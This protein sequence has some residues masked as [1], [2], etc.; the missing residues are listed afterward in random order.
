[1]T[2]LAQ[3]FALDALQVEPLTGT[4]SGPGGREKL[5]PKVMDV[6][7]FMAG[8]AGQV[9]LREDLL[10]RLWPNAVVTDDAITRCF[11]E[12]R[13]CLVRA[14]GNDH[15]RS[16]VETVPKRGYRLNATVQPLEPAAVPPAVPEPEPARVP[17]RRGA[18]IMAAG[19]AA[20]LAMIAA[21][22][23]LWRSPER[24]EAPVGAPEIRAIAVLPFLD[25]SAET[26]QGYF[27][28][29]VTEEILNRLSQAENLRVISRTSSF[30]LRNA[31]LDVPQIADRLGVDY[32]L[33]GSIRKAGGR[34][35]ITAQLIDVGTN[36][37]AWSRTYD[38][39]LDDVFAVQDEIAASVAGAL[40]ATLAGGRLERRGPASVEAYEAYLQGQFFYNRRA[41]GDLE[42]AVSYYETAVERDPGYA[43]AWAALSGA[44]SLL[45]H[46]GKMPRQRGQSLQREA[47]LRAV[48]L[49]P[50]LAVA[51]NRLARYYFETGDR[52]KA[53]EH[54][55]IARALDP[56]DPLVLGGQAGMATRNGDFETAIAIGQRLV[57]SDPLS[58]LQ[59]N[60]LGS[61]L[62]AAGRF[63]EAIAQFRAARELNPESGRDYDYRIAQLHVLLKQPELADAVVHGM[64]PGPYRDQALALLHSLPARRESADAALARIVERSA[65]EP[66]AA[67]AEIY[68]YRGMHE[69]AI[70]ALELAWQA[71]QGNP[72]LV[73]ELSHRFQL[74]LITSPFLEPLRKDP[75]LQ[76]L[77]RKW[78]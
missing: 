9:V 59:R 23:Y 26:D 18:R 65:Q 45:I 41:D 33:E 13:R 8:H 57:A 43:R 42:R 20:V 51:Q 73:P 17:A 50:N 47:A 24:L 38:R 61:D 11:Y 66:S 48:E 74:E 12:L 53:L 6:L 44:Y 27:S 34:V 49:D 25:M 31:N 75:R 30:A 64:E 14:G 2:T 28:D 3:G 60:N 4:V 10:A 35:R 58:P 54:N 37:H 32:V 36:A 46:H 77:K 39:S 21:L 67:L 5:D 71:L 68:A 78:S 55:R 63:D 52:A 7:V 22:L 19:S 69:E 76:A 72:S 16:L 62:M 56:D 1:M 40:Q 70:D 29:G 15:Y